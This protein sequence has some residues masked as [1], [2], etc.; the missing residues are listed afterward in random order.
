[1]SF[2]PTNESLLYRRLKKNQTVDK[3]YQLLSV[4]NSSIGRNFFFNPLKNNLNND[5]Y[6]LFLFFLF[7]NVIELIL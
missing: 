1:M 4:H 6:S 5:L 2:D 7:L 3:K